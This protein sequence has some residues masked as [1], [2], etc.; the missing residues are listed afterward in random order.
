MSFSAYSTKSPAPRI[1][2]IGAG[3][4]GC[5]A[6]VRAVQMG[7]QV[8]VFEASRT[9]GGRA[10]SVPCADADG[11]MLDN[12]QHIL[13]GAYTQTLELM[14]AVG[15]SP[16][17]LLLRLPLDLRTP[18]GKGLQLRP[19]A[20][21]RLAALSA[22]VRARGWSWHEKWRLLRT[23]AQ[24]QLQGFACPAHCSVADLCQ[25]LGPTVLRELIEPLCV[26]A[27]NSAPHETS[28]AV[29]LRVLQDALFSAAGASDALIARSPFGQLLPEPAL[30]WLQA[31]GAQ[32]HL[33]NRVLALQAHTHGW[34]LQCS[35]PAEPTALP[36]KSTSADTG[37]NTGVDTGT[38]ARE[39]T[40]DSKQSACN[41]FDRVIL[42]CPAWEASR[43]V[44]EAA[45]TFHHPSMT[46]AEGMQRWARQ[47]AAL[48]HVPIATL[49]AW[50]PSQAC[51]RLRP[52]Q[53]LACASQAEAQFVF[54]HAHRQR[55]N[56][57]GAP[58]TLL[59]FVAS[60]CTDDR[61]ALEAAI[62]AQAHTQLGLP[63]LHI[64]RTALEKRATFVCTPALER[65]AMQIAPGLLACGDYVQGPYP[66]TLEGAVRSGQAAAQASCP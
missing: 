56:A 14:R 31:Q 5:A 62:T 29:F 18:D 11:G 48:R 1:A 21:A 13:I 60:H 49:Y 45:A 6:A 63:Q 38:K 41:H 53:A 3:W 7:A 37:S 52:M 54:H 50:C 39:T 24:W 61:H 20:S 12:G 36:Q 16:D 40:N 28:G 9:P 55:A 35:Q 10:R 15:A 30:Q 58:E 34:Q 33:G 42:A 25:S 26:A 4:A 22:I 51:A 47:A 32:V 44:Q 65:P 66:A 8:S 2:V 19:A 64:I 43:L 59:A 57:H 27:F 23:A 17:A 46:G